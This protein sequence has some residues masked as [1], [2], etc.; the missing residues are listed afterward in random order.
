[1]TDI[2][3]M[4]AVMTAAKE[5]KTIQRQSRGCCHDYDINAGW[6][7]TT[8]PIWNWATYDYRAKPA[9]PRRIWVNWYPTLNCRSL[10]CYDSREEAASLAR[11][12]ITEQIEFVEAVK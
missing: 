12:D 7:D 4:I 3:H 8:S 9:E 10:V 2:D 5:G 11:H 1:M 6:Y